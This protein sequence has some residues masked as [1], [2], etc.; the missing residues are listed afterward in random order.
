MSVTRLINR[1]CTLILRSQAATVED[2]YGTEIPG[3]T[4]EV[5][6]VCELQQIKRTE[7]PAAGETSDALYNCFFQPGTRCTTADAV[8]IDGLVYE[9]VGDPDIVRSPFNDRESHVHATVRRA[10]GA[11]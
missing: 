4:E 2:D 5:E 1:P 3:E 9:M 10:G 6:T 7:P 11:E 8:R